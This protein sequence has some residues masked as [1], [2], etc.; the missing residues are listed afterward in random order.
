MRLI[1]LLTNFNSGEYNKINLMQASTTKPSSLS[2]QDAAIPPMFGRVL[3]VFFIF[4]RQKQEL[5][6]IREKGSV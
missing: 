5:D 4:G 2:G 1:F 3:T 6:D